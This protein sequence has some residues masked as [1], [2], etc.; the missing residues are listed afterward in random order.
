MAQDQ[1]LEL[2]FREMVQQVKLLT[3]KSDALSLVPG[4]HTLK[5]LLPPMGCL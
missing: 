4:A 5:N 2:R 3:A 1:K